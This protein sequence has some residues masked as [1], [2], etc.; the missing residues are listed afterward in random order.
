MADFSKCSEKQKRSLALESIYLLLKT[1]PRIGPA[2]DGP[3]GI[4]YI[5]ISDTLAN[6]MTA[7]IEAYVERGVS[8]LDETLTD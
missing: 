6:K 4:R 7:T 2:R 8:Y 3:E 1:A 5:Q